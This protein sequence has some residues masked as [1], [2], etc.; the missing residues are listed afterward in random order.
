M[1]ASA[2]ELEVCEETNPLYQ[3]MKF[4]DTSTWPL[5]VISLRTFS[6]RKKGAAAVCDGDSDSDEESPESTNTDAVEA[7]MESF[8]VEQMRRRTG[9]YSALLLDKHATF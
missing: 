1:D 6:N 4:I 8:G 9:Y 7:F 3:D 2:V 5:E